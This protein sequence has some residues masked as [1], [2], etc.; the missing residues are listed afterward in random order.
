MKCLFLSFFIISLLIS[1]LILPSKC[2]TI[3]LIENGGF[4]ERLDGWTSFSY[5]NQLPRD[6]IVTSYL[7]NS[8]KY[9]LRA[10]CGTGGEHCF[11][12]GG[13]AKQYIELN[14]TNNLNLVFWIYLFGIPELNAWT[15][16]AL[17]V[18][19]HMPETNKTL[20]YY[21]AWT[22]N[23]PIYSH[24]PLPSIS[25][26]NISNILIH[27]LKNDKWNYVE[28]DLA[29]DFKNAYPDNS[30]D[31]VQN[32]TFTIVAVSFQRL[33]FT[34]KGSYWDDVSLTSYISEPTTTTTHTTTPTP[35]QNTTPPPTSPT[36]TE[37]A[38]T[39]EPQNKTIG[40]IIATATYGSGMTPE[41][42]F[43]RHVRD[44]MIGSNELG[45]ILVSG[46]NT[47]YYSWSPTLASII[48]NSETLQTLTRILFVPLIVII[49]FTALVFSSIEFIN[50]PLASAVAFY[51]GVS[52]GL[53]VYFII[54]TII[55]L[56]SFRKIFFSKYVKKLIENYS[57]NKK[58][59]NKNSF[60]STSKN[61]ESI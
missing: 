18:D 11:G 57:T 19:F 26:E 29:T 37:P 41:V 43:M 59:R 61:G 60:I 16:I 1:T 2:E 22:D 44:N 24:Y 4:E 20:V 13:G 15:E 35:P 38:P 5:C 6:A 36:P 31:T 32:M 54:P 58:I 40:C 21:L 8:G 46:W 10:D 56:M 48:S 45:R 55:L 9:S 7:S 49:N 50:L 25:S 34:S 47:F 17:I 12:V 39:Q 30:L 14:K 42:S 28:R 51:V 27:D 3:E 52:L 53:F 33:S 23:I